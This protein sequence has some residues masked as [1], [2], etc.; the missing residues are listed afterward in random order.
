MGEI[1]LSLLL[2]I[3]I[4]IYIIITIIIYIRVFECFFFVNK[5]SG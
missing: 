3:H 5:K 1:Y 4:V 2:I